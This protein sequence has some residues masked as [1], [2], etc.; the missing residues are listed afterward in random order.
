MKPSHEVQTLIAEYFRAAAGGDSA[1]IRRHV[2]SRS[3]TRLVGSDPKEWFTGPDAVEFLATE[4]E[5]L[6]G[7]VRL[8][9]GHPDGY[10]EGDIGW[11]I[12]APTVTLANGK[13]VR[14]AGAPSFTGRTGSG[15]SSQ[16]H[17]SI[18]VPERR[19]RA[20]RGVDP[21]LRARAAPNRRAGGCRARRR[22]PRAAGRWETVRAAQHE[23]WIRAERR[24]SFA[25]CVGQGAASGASD[26]AA[27][28]WRAAARLRALIA[29]RRGLGGAFPGARGR[30]PDRPRRPQSAGQRRGR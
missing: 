23:G 25:R 30:P 26:A 12:T 28:T 4:A 14:S 21:A 24:R 11:G 3:E 1:W 20:H 6:G 29:G 13:T 22:S 27:A 2:S 16:I 18:G 9:P 10:E 8:D 15:S 5:E 7:T 19:D 17:A